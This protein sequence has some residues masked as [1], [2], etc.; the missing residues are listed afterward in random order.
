MNRW[1][2]LNYYRIYNQDKIFQPWFLAIL[3]SKFMPLAVLTYRF[4]SLSWVIACTL[5]SLKLLGS[6]ASCI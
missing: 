6:A 3:L 1:E 2:V 4:S 5:L